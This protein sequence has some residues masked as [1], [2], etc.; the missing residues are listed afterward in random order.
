MVGEEA[1]RDGSESHALLALHKAEA[2][3][4]FAYITVY[5]AVLLGILGD[6]GASEEIAFRAR[7]GILGAAK[8]GLGRPE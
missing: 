8:L 1:L 4:G 6:L 7:I 3:E 2:A 5:S